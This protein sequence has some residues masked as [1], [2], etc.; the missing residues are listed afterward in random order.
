M[1]T[2]NGRYRRLVGMV[3]L[4]FCTLLNSRLAASEEEAGKE[5]GR[6]RGTVVAAETQSPLADAGVEATPASAPK[7]AKGYFSLTN[8]DG[9]FVLELPTGTYKV[10]ATYPGGASKTLT[11]IQVQQGKTTQLTISIPT[12]VVEIEELRVVAK[13]KADSE[14]VNLMKR[15]I[16][17][18][19]MD[20]ISAESIKKIPESDVAGILTRMPG[21]V[22]DQGKYMQARGMTKRYNNTTLN[23]AIVPTTRP[24]EKLTPLDLFPA[25][26]VD[27]INVVKSFT[28]DLPGNFSG[29]L[30]QIKTKAVPDDF[31][32]KLG[33]TVKYNTSTTG[34]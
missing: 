1:K 20:N 34:E 13:P 3:L 21:V 23:G 12:S 9:F 8:K 10:T 18:G 11:N 30:C 2:G 22:M 4:T 27:S 29:G 32:M 28:P 16:A 33:Y 25:G 24:N 19:I 26:V 14:M 31:I 15:K 17:S 7:D 6:I 5:G